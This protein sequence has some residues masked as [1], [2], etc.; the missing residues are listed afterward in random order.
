MQT[1]PIR[2]AQQSDGRRESV[3]DN[4]KQARVTYGGSFYRIT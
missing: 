4:P 3:S 1:R 2:M